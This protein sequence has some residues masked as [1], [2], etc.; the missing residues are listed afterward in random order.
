MTTMLSSMLSSTT[1]LPSL[2]RSFLIQNNIVIH[3][4]TIPAHIVR[5]VANLVQCRPPRIVVDVPLAFEL[6]PQPIS[7]VVAA[8]ALVLVYPA[9]VP[10]MAAS[11]SSLSLRKSSSSTVR[12]A[13]FAI[14]DARESS[15]RRFFAF[16][17]PLIPSL[18]SAF[19]P[20]V[21]ITLLLNANSFAIVSPSRLS[22]SF[23]FAED[24][25]PDFRYL[26]RL[27]STAPTPLDWFDFFRSPFELPGLVLDSSCP[28][29]SFSCILRVLS[30]D[31]FASDMLL[32]L[33]EDVIIFG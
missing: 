17:L 26:A 3:A 9:A 32:L 11:A 10:G 22:R 13:R 18:P 8:F 29:V 19:D 6:R 5:I 20:L 12:F 16:P 27:A 28:V 1:T 33:E 7:R 31:S 14:R 2:T 23:L 15:T 24:A 4:P 21:S 30:D 25:V